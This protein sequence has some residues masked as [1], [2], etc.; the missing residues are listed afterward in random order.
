[1]LST[2]EGGAEPRLLLKL[3]HLAPDKGLGMFDAQ[4]CSCAECEGVD[5]RTMPRWVSLSTAAVA[6]A[7]LSACAVPY[8]QGP[9][10]Q[11]RY[12]Q[13]YPRYESRP[14][15]VYAAQ[16][17]PQR[18]MVEYAV[19]NQ[20]QPIVAQQGHAPSGGGALAGG[21]IGG[22]LGNQVGHGSGRAA[23]TLLGAVGGALVGNNVEGR[24]D[25]PRESTVQG[26]RITLAMDRGGYRSYDV[27]NPGDLRPGDPVQVV[28]GQISRR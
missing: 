16:P 10:G 15:P 28:N 19:V 11:Q 18:V 24:M 3:Q 5:M 9:Y 23:A 14:Q 1:M 21:L 2:S 25:N 13:P 26:Y 20:I 12:E 17:Q 6:A 22:V 8:D 4:A 27:G 7:L